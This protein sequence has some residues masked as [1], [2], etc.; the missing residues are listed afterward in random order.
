VSASSKL[1]KRVFLPT[2]LIFVVGAIALQLWAS[3]ELRGL[4]DPEFLR[5]M[6]RVGHVM[7]LANHEYIHPDDATYQKLADNALN[8]VLDGLDKYTY[9]MPPKKY[10][11]FQ[12][13]SEQTYVG[14]GMNIERH[15]GHIEVMEIFPDSP[16]FKATWQVGDRIIAVNDTDVSDYFVSGVSDLLRGSENTT[17]RVT[18]ERTGEKEPLVDTLTRRSIDTPSIRDVTFRPDG[19]A[20]MKLTQFGEH[21]AEEFTKTLKDLM[22]AHKDHLHGLILDLRDNPGGL[23]TASVDFL[24]PLLPGNQLVVSTRGRDQQPDESLYTK[25]KVDGDVYYTGHV[26]VLVN[27]N[28]ASA[29]EIVAGALQ[30]THRA[31]ILGQRTYGK[32]IV[33]SVQDLPDQGGLKITTDAY[34][35]P[36]GRTIQGKGVVPDVPMTLSDETRDVLDFQHSELQ[37]TSPAEFAKYFG[38]PVQPDPEVET[39]ASLILAASAR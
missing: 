31:V 16:A 24:E 6:W 21:S 7:E 30:D 17:V 26:V 18:R 10:A 33:Q 28:S 8:H 5:Q 37:S 35:L 39:A 38:F 1:F 11:D 29:A 27:E 4:F 19:V 25:A 23:L 9:Y 36:S 15:N 12:R 13:E 22:A 3:P 32:G 2:L 34:F 14:V 20:T